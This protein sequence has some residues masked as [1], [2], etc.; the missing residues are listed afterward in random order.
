MNI[1]IVFV[2]L[3][4]TVILSS[5]KKTTDELFDEANALTNNNEY[6]KAIKI[7]SE[8]IMRNNKL[9]LCYYNR[10]FCYL[11][12]KEYGRALLDYNRI[13]DLRTLG[14]GQFIFKQGRYYCGLWLFFKLSQNRI[15]CRRFIGGGE[16]DSCLLLKK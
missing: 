16:N 6:D 12:K 10:G 1:K 8:L 5:C 7:Y 13:I 9:E 14:G 2:I 4:S 15:L 11:S 3:L